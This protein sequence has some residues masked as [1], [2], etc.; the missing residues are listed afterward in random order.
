MDNTLYPLTEAETVRE[1]MLVDM[2]VSL[3]AMLRVFRPGSK[4]VIDAR[5]QNTFRLLAG[6]AGRQDFET[7]HADFCEWFHANIYTSRKVLK[8]KRVQESCLLRAGW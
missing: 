5:I 6:V 2:A 4:L 7:L 1:K 3:S 8:N